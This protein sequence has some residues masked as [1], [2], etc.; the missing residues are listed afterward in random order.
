MAAAAAIDSHSTLLVIKSKN[1]RQKRKVS[2]KLS[3]HFVWEGKASLKAPMEPAADAHVILARRTG[4]KEELFVIKAI[5][6][7]QK[8]WQKAGTRAG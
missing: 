1:T 3:L 2:G 6:S 7:L 5:R 4:F 8:A